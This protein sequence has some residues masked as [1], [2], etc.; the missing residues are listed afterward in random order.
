M[1]S[2]NIL[3]IL[4]FLAWGCL[5]LKSWLT[6]QMK[7][8]IHP[9]Y[10]LP[11][12]V[13]GCFLVGIALLKVIIWFVQSRFGRRREGNGQVRQVS[14][15]P[16][17]L[18]S[19]FLLGMAIA[20]LFIVPQSL[21]SAAALDQ[22][23]EDYL[24][25]T[26][27]QPPSGYVAKKPVERSIMDWQEILNQNPEP[28]IYTGQE[29]KVKGFVVHSAQLDEEYI[30]LSRL[31][32]TSGVADTYPVA[33]PVNLGT[34]RRQDYPPDTWVEVEGEMMTEEFNQ[35][36][37]IAIAADNIRKIPLPESPYETSWSLR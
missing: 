20:S 30:L 13:S 4:V 9:D 21:G 8:L 14:W 5:I 22:G 34:N 32:M 25:L 28:D 19:V 3:D 24:T 17:K 1:G 35:T 16:G 29:V 27:S 15:V 11:L 31:V 18:S 7:D 6:G 23:V 10:V 33:L 12:V 26:P 2:Q 36:R 37:Q